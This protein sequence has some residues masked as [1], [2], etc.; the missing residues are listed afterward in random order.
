M[1]VGVGLS[2][3][4]KECSLTY[5]LKRTKSNQEPRLESTVTLINILEKC[6]SDQ[7]LLPGL[8]HRFYKL[9]IQIVYR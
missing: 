2:K 3:L 4:C 1:S 7:V 6:N 5:D 9:Q 8:L